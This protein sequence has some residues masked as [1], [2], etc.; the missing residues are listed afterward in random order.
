[1]KLI[2]ILVVLVLAALTML[3]FVGKRAIQR[4]EQRASPLTH[5]QPARRRTIGPT[6]LPNANS[7]SSTP[8]EAAKEQ[9]YWADAFDSYYKNGGLSMVFS[10]A[11]ARE[12]DMEEVYHALSAVGAGEVIPFIKQA[13]IELERYHEE[14]DASTATFG[15]DEHQRLVKESSARVRRLEA[16]IDKTGLDIDRLARAYAKEHGFE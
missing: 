9:D 2:L 14:L 15:S 11:D 6:S 4:D 12:W 8:K 3:Y 5:A 13:A 7:D 16:A 1:M 10:T